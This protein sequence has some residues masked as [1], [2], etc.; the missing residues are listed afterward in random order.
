[1]TGFGG[2][3]AEGMDKLGHG[4][5]AAKKAIGHGVDVAT[6]GIGAGLDYVGAHDWVDKVEDFG[7]DIAHD[8]G[9]MPE[10][11]L[12]QTQ[13]AAELS[14]GKPAAIWDS[15]AHLQDFRLPSTGSDR[16]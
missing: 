12:G 9:V 16:G 1:M 14:H 15:V 6:D 3:V 4:V 5:D 11:Q 8:L 10:K 2:L 7:D 13:Q